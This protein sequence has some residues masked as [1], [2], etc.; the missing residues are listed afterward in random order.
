MMDKKVKDF[1]EGEH[2]NVNLLVAANQRGI[3]NTGSPYLNLTLQDSTASIDTKLW[4]VKP[5]IEKEL[6]VGKVFN[7]DLEINK[8][9]GNLQAKVIKVLPIAQSEINIDDF[10]FRSPMSKD[11]LRSVVDDGLNAIKNEKIVRIVSAMLNYY[12]NDFYEY[13]AASKIHHNF[14]GGLATHTSGMIKVAIALC[15]IY[16]S[17]C[18]DYL[19]AGVILHDLGKIEE[20][21]SPVVT[22]YTTEGKLLGHIS[23]MDARMLQIGKELKVED[24]EELMILRHLIL[25]HHGQYEFGSP[26]RPETMEAE[27]L[28]LIDNIDS[29]VNIIEKAIAETKEG[30]FT[31][32]IFALDNRIFYHFHK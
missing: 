15:E 19:I 30:E 8:Y 2:V 18:K 17:I 13:P 23:I 10:I 14:I 12:A 7:F 25:S 3:T 32:K 1:I 5:E 28:T 29:R 6:M 11:E 31:Q 21:T 22:E 26:V 9:K 27:I 16:P 20:F 24:S 4:D